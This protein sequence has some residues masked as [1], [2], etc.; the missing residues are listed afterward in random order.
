MQTA[1]KPSNP[2]TTSLSFEERRVLRLLPNHTY[3]QIVQRTGWSRG[4][5]YNLAIKVGARKT[6]ARIQERQ[7]QRRQRQVEFLNEVIN[8]T[9]KCDVLDFLDGIPT[10][11]V[12]CHITSFPYNLGK[13]YGDSPTAD[14]MRFTFYLGW[15]LQI[16]S[17]ISRTLTPGGTLCLNLG[18]TRDWQDHLMPLDILLYDFIRQAGLTFQSR[19][20]WVLPHGLT[21]KRRLSERHETILVFSKGEQQTFNP[22]AVRVPQ[23]EPGK[24]AFKGPNKGRLSGHPFGAFPSNV[25]QIPHV[26]HN[27]SDLRYLKN[28]KDG[29]AKKHP[30]PFPLALA[31]RAVLLYS[32]PGDIICD[33]FSGSGTT[34]QATIETGRAFVGADLFYESTRALRLAQAVPDLVCQLPGVTDESLAVWQAE[35]V[36]VQSPAP[37]ITHQQEATMIQKT[38]QY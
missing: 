37:F 10:N 2:A 12:P 7:E 19:I 32:M 33:V 34:H 23:K 35:A 25:W 36:K 11:S 27:S 13:P 38:F 1:T 8:T 28:Q 3:D 5:I 17:E 31:R 6:E 9:A 4:R 15:T 16:I 20:I 26:G 18:S 30:A 22:N 14:N 21:P 29:L 24:R